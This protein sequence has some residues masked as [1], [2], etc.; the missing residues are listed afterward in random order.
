M[1]KKNTKQK[2]RFNFNKKLQSWRKKCDKIGKSLV[3]NINSL[4]L[5]RWN[6]LKF[7]RSG[8]VIWLVIALSLMLAGWHEITK[9]NNTL[10]NS[11]PVSSGV[12]TEGV[13]DKVTTINP[14]YAYTDSEKAASSLVFSGLMEYDNTGN[15]RGK[16]AKTWSHDTTGK[17][18]SFKLNDNL[19]WS[20]G[21][22]LTA[23]DVK[24]TIDL[25]K[26]EKIK[27]PL[28]N[29]WKDVSIEA[30]GNK[31]IIFKLKEPYVYFPSSLTF[32]ILPKHYFKNKDI[33]QINSL[34]KYNLEDIPHSGP[35]AFA[36]KEESPT[37]TTWRFNSQPINNKSK[38]KNRQIILKAYA[39][40]DDL[41][42]AMKSSE[43]GVAVN[44]GMDDIDDL[45]QS[46]RK[47]KLIKARS[48]DGVFAIFNNESSIGSDDTIRQALR[49]GLN[50]N[51]IT[52]KLN[53][54]KLDSPIS[55]DIYKSI[56]DL[57][58]PIYN[59]EEANR[60]LDQ[61]GYKKINQSPYRQKN[62][63]KLAIEMVSIKN[64]NYEQTAKLIAKQWGKLGVEVSLK[65]V[66]AGDIQQ[67]YIIPRKYDVL[68]YQLHLGSNPDQSAYWSS[69]AIESGLNFANY[70]S[71]HADLA[72][73]A[74][75][76]NPDERMREAR[77]LAFSK[78]WIDDNPAIALYQPYIY[79]LANP[80]FSSYETDQ[81]INGLENRFYNAI[82]WSAQ[83]KKR[84]TTP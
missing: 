60:L 74:G 16:L 38:A 39:S 30:K 18:W 26:N 64:S 69:S 51:E 21:Q 24:W 7:V 4:L 32:G 42:K 83:T 6:R 82:N 14:L 37:K 67:K 23:D 77:Y 19:K 25:I 40:K 50:R 76:S 43:I 13:V 53:V 31:D 1:A 73:M 78:R 65:L 17:N 66:N 46:I 80:N 70:K 58:Q 54:P 55:R 27:S 61:S 28:F 44:V 34:F 5:L 71:R 29:D 68:V 81:K 72:L 22:N 52:R 10:K 15:I 3:K 57:D 48:T 33:N 41:S 35:F 2:K 56:D 47:L 49:L 84:L 20:N 75:R 79:C 36:K 8:I 9:F 45:Q 63:A 11:R 59:L 12:Y 62:G